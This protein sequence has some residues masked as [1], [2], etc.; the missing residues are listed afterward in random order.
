M[1]ILNKQGIAHNKG[2]ETLTSLT[3]HQTECIIINKAA[4]H[5]QDAA[6]IMSNKTNPGKTN[7]LRINTGSVGVCVG[8]A[9]ICLHLCMRLSCSLRQLE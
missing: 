1:N 4:I 9:H 7:I 3:N 8:T 6:S 5:T 2:Q